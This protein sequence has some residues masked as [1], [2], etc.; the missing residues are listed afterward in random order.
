MR[1][2]YKEAD[3]VKTEKYLSKLTQPLKRK[4]V[5]ARE[6]TFK[7]PGS[8]EPIYETTDYSFFK[9]EQPRQ[10]KKKLHRTIE[11]PKEKKVVV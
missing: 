2:V 6:I 9:E 4:S 8:L 5:E 11:E 3:P 7:V 10:V 1:Q